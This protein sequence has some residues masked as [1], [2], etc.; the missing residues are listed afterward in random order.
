[1]DQKKIMGLLLGLL[2]AIIK[3]LAN[4]ETIRDVR[5]QL[6]GAAE[7]YG[8]A[9]QDDDFSSEQV[10]PVLVGHIFDQT[11]ESKP[12]SLP[13]LFP[14]FATLCSDREDPAQLPVVD[15]SVLDHFAPRIAQLQ[16][17]SMQ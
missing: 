15:W 11:V 5:R 10:A 3:S 4:D 14:F 8:A 6:V 16:N 13:G 2:D 12:A 17:A 7:R 1:M 9:D